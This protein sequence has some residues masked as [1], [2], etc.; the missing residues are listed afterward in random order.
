MTLVRKIEDEIQ[1]DEGRQQNR[2]RMMTVQEQKTRFKLVK[3]VRKIES[4]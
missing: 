2:E 4:G 1:D 3:D